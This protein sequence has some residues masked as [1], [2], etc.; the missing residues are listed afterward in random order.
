MKRSEMV[1]HL[2]EGH[3]HSVQEARTLSRKSLDWLGWYHSTFLHRGEA[4]YAYR[5]EPRHTHEAY[6]DILPD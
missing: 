3:D 5:E 1:V 6:V 4:T 2:Q